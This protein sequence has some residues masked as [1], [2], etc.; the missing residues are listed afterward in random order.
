[1]LAR[2]VDDLSERL[3]TLETKVEMRAKSEKLNKAKKR[4]VSADDGPDSPV[5]APA[6][7]ASNLPKKPT[8]ARTCSICKHEL[9]DK[10]VSHG[11]CRKELD[12]IKQ[13]K[14]ASK[15]SA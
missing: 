3:A 13:A 14:K 7:A 4:L 8:K 12:L 6:A 15:G 5:A 11:A 10:N 2:T 1:M 9:G